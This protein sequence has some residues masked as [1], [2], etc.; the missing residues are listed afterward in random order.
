[1]LCPVTCGYKNVSALS[2][3]ETTGTFSLSMGIQKYLRQ[4]KPDKFEDLIA[5]NAL[6]RRVRWNT[7]RNSLTVNTVASRSNT[8][9]RRW[10]SFCRKLTGLPFTRAG[11]VAKEKLAGAGKGDA[12]VFAESDG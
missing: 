3:G 6:Y 4:L 5:M 7:F 1:M 8:I 2:A 12:D 11:D 9:C 10:K